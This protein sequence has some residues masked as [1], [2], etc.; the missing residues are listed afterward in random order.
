MCWRPF[1]PP[2]GL[3]SAAYTQSTTAEV[4]MGSVGLLKEHV[5]EKLTMMIDNASIHKAKAMKSIVKNLEKAG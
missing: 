5:G 1:S 4:F 3:F 2:V